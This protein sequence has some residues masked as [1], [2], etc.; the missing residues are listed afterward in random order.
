MTFAKKQQLR[1]TQTILLSS[2]ILSMAIGISEFVPE[3]H[4]SCGTAQK[5]T[6]LAKEDPT[7]K[8]SEAKIKIKDF[9]I[10]GTTDDESYA[11]AVVGMFTSG[12]TNFVEGGVWQGY[13]DGNTQTSEAYNYIVRNTANL[14][15]V[16]KF[17]DLTAAHS[18]DPD[19]ED[20]VKVTVFF[21]YNSGL[22]LY[23]D[24]YKVIIYNETK[25][26]TITISD[27]WSNGQGNY[28]NTHTEILN[29]DSEVKA[30]F[31]VIKDYS[32]T[33][34]SNW[35]GSGAQSDSPLCHNKV[36]DTK[37]RMGYNSG[38]GCVYS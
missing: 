33:S 32:G 6:S 36:S 7:T 17:V 2:I 14:V 24:Y 26:H 10:C 12:T 37:F 35:S 38:S 9:S 22:P 13:G 5:Y 29:H 15:Q 19:D 3:A 28:G 31:D 25:G 23:R 20:V 34:W 21:D 11:H 30:E 18:V 4:A 1:K 16:Y 27:I 8:G